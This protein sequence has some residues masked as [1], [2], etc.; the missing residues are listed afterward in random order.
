M[1]S[2]PPP[3]FP[4]GRIVATPGAFEALQESGQAPEFFIDRHVAGDWGEVGPGD[5]KLNDL[6]LKDG[7]RILSAYTTL[8]AKKLW[9]ITEATDD[10]G[11]RAATTILLPEDY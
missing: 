4:L 7:G 1:P 6:A 8:K 3:K 9:I 10:E 11:I 5:W 2:M